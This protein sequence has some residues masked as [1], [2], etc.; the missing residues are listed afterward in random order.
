M[1]ETIVTNTTGKGVPTKK[2]TLSHT[3]ERLESHWK[4]PLLLRCLEESQRKEELRN[5]K[6]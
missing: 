3:V 2:E 1:D 4:P 5:I 6:S